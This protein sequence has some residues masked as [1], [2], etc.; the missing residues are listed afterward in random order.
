MTPQYILRASLCRAPSCAGPHELRDTPLNEWP[1]PALAAWRHSAGNYIENLDYSHE[2][3]EPGYTNPRKSILFSNW[4]LFPR[5]VCDLLESA[6]Y[7]LEWEDEWTRCDQCG[8]ALRT[9]PDSY[10]WQP[11]FVADESG[12]CCVDCLGGDDEFLSDYL[13]NHKRA[14]NITGLDL[15]KFGYHEIQCGFSVGWSTCSDNPEQIMESVRARGYRNV[16]FQI[17]DQSQF[18]CGFCVW[19]KPCPD[20]KDSGWVCAT[21]DDGRRAI[22]RCDTCERF[23][24]DE[25]AVP[26]AVAAGFECLPEYPCIVSKMAQCECGAAWDDVCV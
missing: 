5:K 19:Y 16:L 6:G 20:C 21:R 10:Q 2:Y 8:K 24:S 18:E 13:D 14:V 11:S 9:S 3:A 23:D 15:A 22:E 12:Y 4:N 26:V 7:S 25:S 17:S 1:A